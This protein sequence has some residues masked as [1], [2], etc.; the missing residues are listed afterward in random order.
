V[1]PRAPAIAESKMVV[2]VNKRVRSRA[3]SLL[4]SLGLMVV[5]ENQKPPKKETCV[6]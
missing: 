6:C 2:V 4:Y 5:A 3:K 1:S